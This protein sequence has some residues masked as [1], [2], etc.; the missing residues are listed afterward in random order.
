META[1]SKQ[2]SPETPGSERRLLPA[3]LRAATTSRRARSTRLCTWPGGTRPPR[4]PEATRGEF[5]M[6]LPPPRPCL[7][8]EDRPASP[9]AGGAERQRTLRTAGKRKGDRC[10]L[11]V[12]SNTACKL[13]GCSPERAPAGT[14]PQRRALPQGLPRAATPREEPPAAPQAPR[15][16]SIY[17]PARLPALNP[18]PPRPPPTDASAFSSPGQSMDPRLSRRGL[19]AARPA[20][21]IPLGSLRRSLPTPPS[22]FYLRQAALRTQPRR[23]VEGRLCASGPSG[24]RGRGP[25]SRGRGRPTRRAARGPFRGPGRRKPQLLSGLQLARL[26]APALL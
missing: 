7:P 23:G 3:A 9:G 2:P 17:P 26:S 18:I 10:A 1:G 11:K 21:A 20:P 22:P 15:R 16:Q 6:N 13:L 8:P 4:L 5:T 25:V 14:L 24:G 19:G 12:N